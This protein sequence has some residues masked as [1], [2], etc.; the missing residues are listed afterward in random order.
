MVTQG[1][2]LAELV[3]VEFS[4]TTMILL[5][6]VYIGP[7]QKFEYCQY[8][9]F[10]MDLMFCLSA[11]H[12]WESMFIQLSKKRNE[13]NVTL[14][15]IPSYSTQTLLFGSFS[16]PAEHLAKQRPC[17]LSCKLMAFQIPGCLLSKSG[18]KRYG[19]QF[20]ESCCWSNAFFFWD[21]KKQ[22]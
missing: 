16:L 13:Q 22:K 12:L 9:A 17:K 18:L 10:P 3:I 20:S 4:T 14:L 7:V 21:V 6:W 5:I 15:M 19:R 1:R 11:Q 2:S 8:C